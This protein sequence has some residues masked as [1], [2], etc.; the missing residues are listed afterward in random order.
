MNPTLLKAISLFYEGFRFIA[1]MDEAILSLPSALDLPVLALEENKDL[2]SLEMSSTLSS[3]S[4]A[5]K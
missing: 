3:L 1:F 4:L 5:I 2:N